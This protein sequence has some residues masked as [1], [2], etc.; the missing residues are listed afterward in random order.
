ME[1]LA[2]WRTRS[3]RKL[4]LL[5]SLLADFGFRTVSTGLS[6]GALTGGEIREFKVR[7]LRILAAKTDV[8]VIAP[9]CEKCAAE[10]LKGNDA[11]RDLDVN[12]FKKEFEI[13]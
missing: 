2:C 1:V 8:L 7:A 13:Y 3:R 12:E 11:F 4:R 6:L 5:K 9:L 10:A